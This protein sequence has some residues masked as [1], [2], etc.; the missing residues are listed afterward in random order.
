MR[1]DDKIKTHFKLN[2]VIFD[3]WQ[4][5]DEALKLVEKLEKEF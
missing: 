1:N 4:V 5:I 2:G 3:M